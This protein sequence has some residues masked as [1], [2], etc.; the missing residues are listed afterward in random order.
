MHRTIRERKQV[1]QL[2]NFGYG[3][4]QT[5]FGAALCNVLM[6]PADVL[7]VLY[8]TGTQVICHKFPYGTQHN[9]ACPTWLPTFT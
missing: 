2:F 7:L 6:I 1:T 8:S 5:I 9:D 3:T 4:E